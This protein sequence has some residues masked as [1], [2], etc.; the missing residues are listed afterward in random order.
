[1][2]TKDYADHDFGQF[3]CSLEELTSRNK[4]IMLWFGFGVFWLWLFVEVF[5]ILWFWEEF[6]F[7]ISGESQSCEVTQS[8]NCERLVGVGGVWW[9]LLGSLLTGMAVGPL[10][11]SALILS[12]RTKDVTKKWKEAI[13]GCLFS[14]NPLIIWGLLWL[15]CLP[16]TW[17]LLPWGEW[18]MNWWKLFPYVFGLIWIGGMPA[19]IMIFSFWNL[20]FNPKYNLDE[21][22]EREEKENLEEISASTNSLEAGLD[23]V[24]IWMKEATVKD[25]KLHGMV[26]D[27]PKLG[28]S[29]ITTSKIISK[30]L[31]GSVNH[32]ETQNTI[33]LIQ[34][35]D[36]NSS[37]RQNEAPKQLQEAANK[38]TKSTENFW[39]SA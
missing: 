18:S 15:V 23:K 13:W 11:F 31:Q 29:K 37:L 16:Y 36:L 32:I 28:T 19:L 8:G 17:G 7:S 30:K 5:D 2:V 9:S 10:V 21:E 38:V 35:S 33:Y 25:D 14:V 12:Y 1:M 20:F 22:K 26:I 27:H 3:N 4:Q 39:D 24:E 34:E 6:Y